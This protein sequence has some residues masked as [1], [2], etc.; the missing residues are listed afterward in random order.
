MWAS[1][2]TQTVEN[3]PALQVTQVQSLGQE[4]PLGKRTATCSSTLGKSHGQRRLVGYGPWARK[5]SDMTERLT[6]HFQHK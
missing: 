3:L 5:K 1:L 2:G 6:L 4:E